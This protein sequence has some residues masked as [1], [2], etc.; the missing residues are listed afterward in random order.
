MST[1]FG[2]PAAHLPNRQIKFLPIIPAIQ[3]CNHNAWLTAI[4]TWK[5]IRCL[6]ENVYFVITEE[7]GAMDDGTP[8]M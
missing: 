5:S 7:G 6:L 8:V 1:V 3:Y 2:G 4:I